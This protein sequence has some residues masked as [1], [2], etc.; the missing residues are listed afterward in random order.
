M[1]IPR[2]VLQSKR[3]YQ[4]AHLSLL[5]RRPIRGPRAQFQSELRRIIQPIDHSPTRR[6]LGGRQAA[7]AAELA[8]HRGRPS[9]APQRQRVRLQQR[10][11]GPQ[12]A[13]QRPSTRAEGAPRPAGVAGLRHRLHPSSLCAFAGTL[14]LCSGLSAGARQVSS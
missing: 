12:G 2:S 4:P 8:G 6:A 9:G 3:T 1:P 13:R 10:R 7:P 11:A 14:F 5:I